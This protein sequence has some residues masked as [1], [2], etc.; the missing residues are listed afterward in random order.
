M[1]KVA[2][3]IKPVVVTIGETDF[4]FKPTVNDANNYTNHV[5]MDSKVEPA[6][7]YLERTVDVS[8]KEELVE[9]MNTVPGLVMEVFGLVHESSKGGISITLKN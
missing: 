4:T 2:F 7:T 6:R 8:Q 5:S 1:A 9:L 3:A